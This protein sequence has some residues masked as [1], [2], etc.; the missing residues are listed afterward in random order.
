VVIS[1]VVLMLHFT[2]TLAAVSVVALLAA[3][4]GCEA[5]QR[6]RRQESLA[7]VMRDAVTVLGVFGL[8]C[9]LMLTGLYYG[10][11]FHPIERYTYARLIQRDWVTTEYN[12]YW[13]LS[14][15]LGYF[16][17]FGLAQTVL[18]LVQAG[19]PRGAS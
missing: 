7:V 8:V 19:R 6:L 14:N 4:L 16:L 1:A 11:H 2:I 5:W 12:W 3:Y 10:I 17:S 18:L 15:A 13:V 9:G